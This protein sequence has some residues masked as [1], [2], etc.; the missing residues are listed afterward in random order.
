[1]QNPLRKKSRIDH[2][3]VERQLA[4]SRERAQSYILAGK[5]WIAGKE[6]RKASETYPSD[7]KIELKGEDHPYVS[8]G[9]VKLEGALKSFNLEVQDKVVLDV[10]ASTGGFTDCLLQQ[11]ARKV[12]AIDVGYGQLD[13]KLRQDP[14]VIVREKTHV[15]DLKVDDFQDPIHLA[16]VDVSFISLLKVI[17]HLLKILIKPFYILALIKPQFEAGKNEVPKGGVIQDNLQREQIVQKVIEGIR[18]LNVEIIN[19]YPSSLKGTD[20][21]QEYFAL[22]K[23]E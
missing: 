12:Y 20:G 8:R 10:G 6:V 11:G 17:P 2:L 3:L 13:W 22:L 19:V 7:V 15:K 9:G 4:P 23:K 21:N 16:V 18:S 5:V 1:M 14:R